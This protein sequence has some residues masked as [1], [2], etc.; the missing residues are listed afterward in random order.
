VANPYDSRWQKLR[1][2]ILQRDRHTCQINGPGC[3]H[4]ATDV[5]HII[6]LDEGGQRLDPTNL[7]A[8][9]SHCNTRRPA[10]RKRD[11]L[12]AAQ[13]NTPTTP[14]ASRTW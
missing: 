6:P 12:T 4:T 7:R 10:Q 9:C 14:T 5:D 2:L 11:L 3:T 1:P 8:A 13:H